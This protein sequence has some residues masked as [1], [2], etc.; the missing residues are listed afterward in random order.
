MIKQHRVLFISAPIGAG[1]LR[2]AQAVKKALEIYGD[3]E[4][5][6]RIAIIFDF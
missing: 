1:H 4:V 6:S 2:A 3:T 5:E